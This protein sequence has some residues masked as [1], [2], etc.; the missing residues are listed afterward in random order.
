M[1]QSDFFEGAPAQI[2]ADLEKPR[3]R[4]PIIPNSVPRAR[5]K[6]EFYPTL[7]ANWIVPA[8]LRWVHLSRG[9]WEPHAGRGHIARELVS[10]GYRVIATDLV[11]YE[12]LP[13]APRI[14]VGY[15]FLEQIKAPEGVGAVVMNPPYEGVEDHVA[16]ALR[17][18]SKVPGGM[19]ACL[20]RGEWAHAKTRDRLVHRH[21]AFDMKIELTKRPK[22]VE[23]KPDEDEESPRHNFAWFVWRIDRRDV[24]PSIRWAP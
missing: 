22:W 2:A 7:N 16:A 9:V 24:A 12:P 14:R 10:A 8:L 6:D 13:G 20:L 19:V 23:P 3:R 15:D 21:P 1:A 18:M 17:I 11:D 4:D 5:I